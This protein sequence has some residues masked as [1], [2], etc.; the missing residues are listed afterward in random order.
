MNIVAVDVL[1]RFLV[2]EIRAGVLADE[3]SVPDLDLVL[4]EK[5]AVFAFRVSQIIKHLHLL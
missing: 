2:Q 1:A 4:P 3:L 5:Y